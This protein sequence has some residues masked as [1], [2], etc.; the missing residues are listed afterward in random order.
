MSSFEQK[1]NLNNN[2]EPT[3]NTVQQSPTFVQIEG[4]KQ[5]LQ[6]LEEY[7]QG[8]VASGSAVPRCRTWSVVPTVTDGKSRI[9]DVFCAYG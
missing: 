4:F 5:Y 2:G 1:N 3:M 9:E 8:A 6:E 7:I